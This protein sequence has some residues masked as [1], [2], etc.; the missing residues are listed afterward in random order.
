M[1]TLDLT[2][3]EARII[4][5]WRIDGAE[6]ACADLDDVIELLLDSNTILP[7]DVEMQLQMLQRLHVLRKELRVF[8]GYEK[9]EGGD[10]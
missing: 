8:A 4:Q 2:D 1:K 9:E 7:C 5:D 6:I 10:E 3:D